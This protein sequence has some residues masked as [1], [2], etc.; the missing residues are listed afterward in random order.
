MEPTKGA[1]YGL[2]D[3]D[4][5]LRAFRQALVLTPNDPVAVL[6]VAAAAATTIIVPS[7]G[8]NNELNRNEVIALLERF[9]K[10]MNDSNVKTEVLAEE[11]EVSVI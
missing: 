2:N 4:N 1:L 5:A 11:E 8:S 6:N 3:T 9:Q 7:V 10:L